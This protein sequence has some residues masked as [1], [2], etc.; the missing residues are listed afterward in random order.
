MKKIKL[1]ALAAFAMLSTNAFAEVVEAGRSIN[2]VSYELSKTTVGDVTTYTAQVKGFATTATDAQKKTVSIPKEVTGD[3]DVVYKV[4]SF[5]ANWAG[6]S[7]TTV[8]SLTIAVDNIPAANFTAGI[9]SCLDAVKTIVITD[10][11]AAADAVITK[12]PKDAISATATG[13]LE[14]VTLSSNITEIEEAAFANCT[15]L[16][17]FNLANIKK[18]GDSAFN[19][20]ALTSIDLTGAETI[21]NAAFA[22]CAGVESLTIPAGVKSVG[23]NAFKAMTKLATVTINISNDDLT[24]VGTWFADDNKIATLTISSAKLT[25][26]ASNAFKDA[27][28]TTLDLSGATALATVPDD[29]FPANKY[30]SVKLGGTK[31][32]AIPAILGNAKASLT[33]I[34]LPTAAGYTTI[35]DNQ[36][37]DFTALTS[38]TIGENVTEIGQTAFKGCEKLTAITLPETLTTIAKGAFRESGLT[39][40]DIPAKV[41]SLADRVFI[42]CADLE[43]VTGMEGVTYIDGYTFSGCEKLT[44]LALSENI[45]TVRGNSLTGTKITSLNLPNC[46]TFTDRVLGDPSATRAANTTLKTVTLGAAALDAYTFANCTALETVTIKQADAGDD[47]AEN[48]FYG[49]TK[50]AAFNYDATSGFL[51]EIDNLA[52][53]GCSNSPLIVITT[54]AAYIENH[55]TAPLNSKYGDGSAYTITTVA[56]KGSS[57]KFFARIC[58]TN[59]ISIEAASDVKVYAVYVDEGTAYFRAFR[60]NGGK[61]M[62]A[63]GDHAIIKTNEAKTIDIEYPGWGNANSDDEIFCVNEDVAVATFQGAPA[64]YAQTNNG[65]YVYDFTNGNYIYRLT[66]NA[67]TG[68]FGFTYFTGSTMKTGQFFIESSTVPASGARLQTVWLDENGNVEGDATAIQKFETQTEDGAIYNLAGQKVSA[69]YKGVVI[70]NGKKYIK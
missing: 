44:S 43:T 24:T 59:D 46:T 4:T 36:F 65:A 17:T 49:C 15:K 64:T 25:A 60:T 9:F 22:N 31:L 21:G 16:T 3:N 18:Y 70:K 38:V 47:I 1:F 41:T 68:G 29:A 53:A 40:I 35:A 11:T 28:I 26:I 37:S 6:A 2:G 61:Y 45:T 27:I 7:N 58:P 30:T 12:F 55:P 63:A 51:G 39:S 48:A 13:K 54:S 32:T 69:S 57:G 23:N 42:N 67:S 20:S 52:F 10:G 5:A 50:L 66:N 34:T 14:S 33:E 56:D 8:E 19:G 62:I